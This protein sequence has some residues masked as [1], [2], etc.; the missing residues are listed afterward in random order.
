MGLLGVCACDAGGASTLLQ[1]LL[2]E[3]GGSPPSSHTRR[4]G[5]LSKLA[6][7]D[8]FQ[9]RPGRRRRRRASLF[10]TPRFPF[11]SVFF[12]PFLLPPLQDQKGGRVAARFP[13]LFS[14]GDISSPFPPFSLDATFS[15]FLPLSNQSRRE[16]GGR[17]KTCLCSP[18][19]PLST[20]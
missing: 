6:I 2:G 17:R 14:N 10:S 3:A 11:S 18:S 9:H 19:I 4:L 12:T 20:G 7:K 8:R 5:S 16:T 13:S 15:S 1:L